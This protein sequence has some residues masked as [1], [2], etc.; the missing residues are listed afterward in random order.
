MAARIPAL[1]GLA[2]KAARPL[3]DAL[4]TFTQPPI[5]RRIWTSGER[6][7]IEVRG[8]HEPGTEEAAQDLSQRLTA[9][10]GVRDAQVNAVL[11]RVVVTHDPDVIR[12]AELARVVEKAERDWEIHDRGPAPASAA[13]PANLG[14]TVREAVALATNAV[15]AT[16]AVLGRALPVGLLPPVLPAVATLVDS[17]PRLRAKVESVLGRPT[18]DAVF[19]VGGAVGQALARR[20]MGL[21]TDA[22]YRMCLRRELDARLQAWQRW[23]AST[24]DRP[25]VH[26]S[27]PLDRAPR[28]APLPDGPVEKVANVSAT[29]A[30]TGLGGMLVA[31]RGLQRATALLAACVPRASKVGR[32]AF[33]AQLAKDLSGSGTLVLDPDALRRLDRVD[34]VVLDASSLR[35][36]RQIVGDIV[37]MAGT[38]DPAKV[39][40]HA[41]DLLDV[42]RP[43]A[44]QRRGKWAVQPAEELDTAPPDEVRQAAREHDT[45]VLAVLRR[46][47]PVGFVSVVPEAD[48]LTE[49]VTE[50]AGRAGAVEVADD[51]ETLL[52][53]VRERQADGQVVALVSAHARAALAAADVGIGVPDR[54][55]APPWGAHLVCPGFAQVCTVLSAVEVA[56]KA[57]RYSAWLSGSGSALGMMLGGV[58]PPRGAITRAYFAVHFATMVALVSGTWLGAQPGR[59]PA[60]IP[61]DRTPWHV[62]TPRATLRRLDTTPE[63][64]DERE[65][66]RRREQVAD[67]E[68]AAPGLAQASADE[69]AGPLTPALTAGAGVSASLGSIADAVLIFCV[70]GLN[71]VIGGAQRVAA[72]RELRQ[73]LDTSALRVRLRRD[74]ATHSQRADDLAPGD[75]IELQ[76]GDAVPADSR[77]LEAHGVEVDESS[78]TGESQLVRKAARATLAPEIA[79]RSSMLYRGSAIAAGRAVAVVVATGTRTEA[80]RSA[81]A[82]GEAPVTGVAARLVSLTKITLPL[83][84]GAG[85]LLLVVDLLR[86]S[87]LSLALGRAV[88]LSVA[89]VPEGLPFVAT[90]AELASAR[91]LA[92]RGVLVRSPSTIEA[93]GRV[94]V[95][96][97]DKTGTLTEG[98]IRLREVSDG[99]ESRQLSEVTPQLCGVLAAA[100]RASPWRDTASVPHPTDRSVLDGARQLEIDAHYGVGELEWIDELG[101]EPSR[102][103]HAVLT[104]TPD[105]LLISVKG[106]PEAVLARCRRWRR[107]DD[108][109]TFDAQARAQAEAE[110][111]RLAGQG[112]RVL[113][114]A[115]R[116]ANEPRDLDEERI[117]S[118]DFCGLLALADPVRPTAAVAVEQ[119]R[120]AGVEIAMITGDHPSTAKAIAAEL[121]LRK[122]KGVMTGAEVDAAD[123]DELAR[124]LPTVAVFARV[125]PAQKARIVQQLHRTGRIVA[126]TGDGAN[127]VPAIRLSHVGIAVGAKATPAAREAADMVVT[128]DRIETITDA[129]VEGRAMWVSVRDAL[130]I[131]LGGNFGEVAFTLTAGLLSSRDTLNARQ[132]LLVNLL[133]DV[134]P[135]MAVAVKPPPHA[136]PEALLAEGPEASLGAML[137]KDIYTRAATT[138]GAA[139]GGWLLARPVST[140]L[141]ASTTALVTLVGAQLGQTMAIRGRTPLVLAAGAGSLLALGAVVQTPGVSQFFGCSPLMPHQWAIALGVSGAATM[142]DVVGR[143]VPRPQV[144]GWLRRS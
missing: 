70:L 142:V 16:Y 129:L 62:M 136:T 64:L 56:H 27:E 13:H 100:V 37:A 60:P 9:L 72:N 122:G 102:G 67:E 6:T 38:A 5:G 103:Y 43:W 54:T 61:Q 91:R 20:P 111:E 26:G 36:G 18:A 84:V 59:R 45:P 74:G 24:A 48:P 125:S 112:Y 135:A 95:L 7:H 58:G 115:E 126:M 68:P 137:T 28:P 57:S 121:D 25:Q 131:L 141:Q 17:T 33:A 128:D 127:D 140:P 79:D 1:L 107:G 94:D 34:T 78:L 73:L 82:D 106:A 99:R 109:V 39:L 133:T 134:L 83:T 11:G 3:T 120:H 113:A 118:F 96:C 119:L 85:V 130:A 49:A 22:G 75:V 46:D 23:E 21:L 30:L 132:L 90:V 139:L 4:H 101:F 47:E 80:E 98:R 55:G 12:G 42:Q 35:T 66:A 51:V 29:L 10:D 14:P 93:L 104:R 114:V 41:H 116:A 89:A 50:A 108:H 138:A 123:D 105:G 40:A 8:V 144:E 63:G 86:R 44:P 52:D 65:S 92:K 32:D 76:A 124:R 143:L 19:A 97:F 69:L 77:L 2:A 88:G 53:L 31:R 81:G 71:A 110:V 117:R 15:G 87:G